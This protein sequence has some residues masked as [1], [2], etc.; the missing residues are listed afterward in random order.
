MLGHNQEDLHGLGLALYASELQITLSRKIRAFCNRIH[1]QQELV[2]TL[3][4]E[5]PVPI[6][7]SCVTDEFYFT[8]DREEARLLL[9]LKNGKLRQ[10]YS[11]YKD[12]EYLPGEDQAIPKSLSRYMDKSLRMPDT[13][14]TCYTWFQCDKNFLNS[15][16][17]QM[18][19]LTH[20][21]PC[22]LNNLGTRRTSP[23]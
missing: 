1:D 4:L 18:Q 2:I 16:S 5:H 10:Y 3:K 9:H 19:Y 7:V 12:Y 22:L 11:N 13:P 20:S 6:S 17:M 8:A 23:S 21:L 15:T 14:Q